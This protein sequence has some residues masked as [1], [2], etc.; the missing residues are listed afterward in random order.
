MQDSGARQ[1]EVLSSKLLDTLNAERREAAPS[2][3]LSALHEALAKLSEEQILQLVGKLPANQLA[4]ALDQKLNPAGV[5]P[6]P[7]ARVPQ[8]PGE[9]RGAQRSK[10]LRAGK[11]IYNGKM[12]VNDCEIRNLSTTGCR[13][14]VESIAG[15]PDHFTLHIVNGDVRH[16]CHVA[17]RQSNVMGLEFIG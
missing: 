16:E 5:A 6:L 17:W 15:I 14:T 1:T 12:S 10:T 7:Q 4:R 11:I 8:E 13:V 3:D 2:I 9:N